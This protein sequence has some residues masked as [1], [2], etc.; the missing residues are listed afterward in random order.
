VKRHGKVVVPLKVRERI[1]RWTCGHRKKVYAVYRP[2]V[3]RYDTLCN[4]CDAGLWNLKV[5]FWELFDAVPRFIVEAAQLERG[6]TR[7]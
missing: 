3:V 1:H 5:R 7:E 6:M 2:K 4:A